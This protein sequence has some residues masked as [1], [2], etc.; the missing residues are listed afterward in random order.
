[1]QLNNNDDS[2]FN[3]CL[4]ILLWINKSMLFINIYN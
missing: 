1:M 3:L 2:D 4:L